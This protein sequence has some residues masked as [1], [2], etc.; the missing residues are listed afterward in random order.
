MSMNHAFAVI[1]ANFG[2]EGKGLT[3]DYLVRK[4]GKPSLVARQN[5]GAQAG[6]TVETKDGKRHVF[7]HIG[8]GTFAGANTYLAR[9]FIL[10]PY[11]LTKEIDQ[12]NLMGVDLED[13]IIAHP[14]CRVTIIYDMALNSLR[15]LS[16]GKG[17]HGS[18]GLGI[19]ETVTRS[20]AGR[21][22]TLG[23]VKQTSIYQMS[24]TLQHIFNEYWKK[25]YELLKDRVDEEEAAPFLQMFE[26]PDF[27]H[28]ATMLSPLKSIRADYTRP[29][30]DLIIEGAQGLML[31][32]QLGIFP[33]VTRSVT[34]LPSSI[35]TAYETFYNEITPVYITRCYLTRHGAGPLK[36]EN[37]PITSTQIP[38]DKTNVTGPWQGHFRYAP[39]DVDTLSLMISRDIQRSYSLSK[40]TGI[41]VNKP[42]LMI[43]CL[44][45]VGEKLNVNLGGQLITILTDELSKVIADRIPEVNVKYLSYGPTAEDVIEL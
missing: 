40:I 20:L 43:T 30:T 44:D 38:T 27:E 2:D 23:M 25:E 14:E 1:G 42:Q 45:Q 24:R 3:T 5:G 16:R 34:G 33:H 13:K 6:H 8:A 31:D 37:L 4:A 41:H 17:R 15:E 7:G 9:Q 21:S 26:N 28:D 11:S 18:C 29:Y 32:E 22:I 10:N 39:L 19:N 12:L 35:L 36:M